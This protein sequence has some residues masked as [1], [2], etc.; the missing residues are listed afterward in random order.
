M[1]KK[2][3]IKSTNVPEMDFGG[4]MKKVG[5][6][7]GDFG[8]RWTETVLSPFEALTG[9]DIVDFKYDTKI[10]KA[11]EKPL[12]VVNKATGSIL[13]MNKYI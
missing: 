13:S 10:G 2:K 6:G 12:D 5:Q 11:L 4:F 3:T 1:K 8:K 9:Q 7:F